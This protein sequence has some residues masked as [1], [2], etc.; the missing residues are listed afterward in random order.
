MFETVFAACVWRVQKLSLAEALRQEYL[1]HAT[2]VSRRADW[3][4]YNA[5]KNP[6]GGK[7]DWKVALRLCLKSI[8]A[9]YLCLEYLCLVQHDDNSLI[10][11][12][13]SYTLS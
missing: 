8:P 9:W 2:I 4:G 5:K 1:R 12:P 3:R 13:I 6:K 7:T 10:M 11:K